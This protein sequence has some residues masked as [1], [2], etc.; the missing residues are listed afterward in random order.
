MQRHRDVAVQRRADVVDGHGFL[1][2]VLRHIIFLLSVPQAETA[3]VMLNI[4]IKRTNG[5]AIITG[6]NLS[7]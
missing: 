7:E 4:G 3:I 2:I 1:E 6:E 5:Q